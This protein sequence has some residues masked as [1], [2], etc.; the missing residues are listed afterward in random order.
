MGRVGLPLLLGM[1]FGAVVR[2]WEGSSA[3][4]SL[5]ALVAFA[6]VLVPLLQQTLP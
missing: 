4:A 6:G 5:V 1:S 2:L 3:V